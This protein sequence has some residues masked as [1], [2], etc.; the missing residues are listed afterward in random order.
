MNPPFVEYWKRYIAVCV[1]LAAV[2]AMLVGVSS[3]ACRIVDGAVY[4]A[5]LCV[6]GIILWHVFRYAFPRGGRYA[7]LPLFISIVLMDI[8]AVGIESVVAY[9]FFPASFGDFAASIPVRLFITFLLFV[10]VRMYYCLH[11]VETLPEPEPSSEMPVQTKEY[12]KRFTV[13]NGPKIGF[14]PI[15]DIFYLQAEG[16]YVAIY[17]A[18]GHWLKEQ[19]MKCS[20]AQLPPDRFIRIHRSYIVN[21]NRIS[22]IERYGEQQLVILR[23][24]VKI[25]ISAAGYRMLRLRL[26]L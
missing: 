9:L 18:E 4:A 3:T 15:E 26:G 12:V 10:I 21:I 19:T 6:A 2:Y 13:R 5:M 25:K 8:L 24:G 22:R 23:N 1:L 11:V 14:I 20:E 17:T 7:S 16:D